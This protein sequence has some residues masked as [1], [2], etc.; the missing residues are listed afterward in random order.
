MSKQGLMSE[1][2]VVCALVL[3]V[4]LTGCST[5]QK[6]A[7]AVLIGGGLVGSAA[8]GAYWGSEI[9]AAFA[10]ADPDIATPVAM[11]SISG[12]L[13]GLGLILILTDTGPRLTR[14]EKIH[15]HRRLRSRQRA[16]EEQ[17]PSL[18]RAREARER[19]LRREE[20]ELRRE[21]YEEHSRRMRQRMWERRQ[22]WERQQ[23]RKRGK[24]WK[25]PN[26][27]PSSQPAPRPTI[28]KPPAAVKQVE[29]TE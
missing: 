19:T 11:W 21:E 29:D 16:L 18:Q 13:M 20:Y 4:V 22:R 3:A 8:A 6:T 2:Q 24:H 14:E 28:P 7:G 5:T 26:S 1:R 15:E 9:D 17:D 27:Q 12:A 23:A 25:W 10:G